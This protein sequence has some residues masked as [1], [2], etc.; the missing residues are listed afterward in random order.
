MVDK[1]SVKAD[2]LPDTDTE[3]IIHRNH[4]QECS[5]GGK[6]F[7][8]SSEY[9][10]FEG[11]YIK[12][13]GRKMEVKCSLHKLYYKQV[14]GVLD[15]S[16]MFTMWDMLNSID[17]LLGRLEISPDAAKITYFEVGLNI[18]VEHPPI[19]YIKL[20]RSIGRGGKIA[21]ID[22]NFQEDRQKTTEKT[23]HVKKVFKVYDKGFE[24]RDRARNRPAPPDPANVLRI[25][26]IYRRQNIRLAEF[27]T[28]DYLRRLVDRFF[29]DWGNVGFDRRIFA[30]KGV[31]EGKR[32]AA[33]RI[34]AVGVERYALELR[35]MYEA[36]TVSGVKFRILSDFV[37]E[38]ETNKGIFFPQISEYEQEYTE[39]LKRFA[40]VLI[41]E[42]QLLINS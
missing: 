29:D 7:Y 36:G 17:T 22:A 20:M 10:R 5:E 37:R 16:Q 39:K 19:E 32:E 35:E 1:I 24:Q 4:L 40:K 25:E 26:T 3:T 18:P 34:Y 41:N 21:F 11:I 8:Q 38:W 27:L 9:G 15:N 2:I 30:P 31:R 12:I 14:Y 28:W 13:R 6:T 42:K 23:R 33:R